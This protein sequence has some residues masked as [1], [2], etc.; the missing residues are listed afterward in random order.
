MQLFK[1]LMQQKCKRYATKSLKLYY[2]YAGLCCDIF[3]M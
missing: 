3:G 1:G 2:T